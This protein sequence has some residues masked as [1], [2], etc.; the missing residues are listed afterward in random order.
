MSAHSMFHRPDEYHRGPEL[1]EVQRLVVVESQEE[2]AVP[3]AV[4]FSAHPGQVNPRYK[5]TVEFLEGPPYPDEDN[6]THVYVVA[7]GLDYGYL[8]RLWRREALEDL[9]RE[10]VRP[11]E[12]YAPN[13]R[14]GAR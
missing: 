2:G 9:P 5:V 7:A 8:N 14:G 6:P 10:L 3:Y 12:L 1:H 4:A 11:V 13:Y